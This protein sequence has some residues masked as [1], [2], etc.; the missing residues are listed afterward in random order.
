MADELWIVTTG[1]V[2][3]HVDAEGKTK[4][5][6]EYPASEL[7]RLNVS[8][9]DAPLTEKQAKAIRKLVGKLRDDGLLSPMPKQ[10]VQYP[11]SKV[12]NVKQSLMYLRCW[13][14]DCDEELGTTADLGVSEG[15]PWVEPTAV[16]PPVQESQAATAASLATARD[17]RKAAEPAAGV[18]QEPQLGDLV[19][20]EE[21]DGGDDVPGQV[22]LGEGMSGPE[23]EAWQSVCNE[24]LS[25]DA[26][27]EEE[28]L[29]V[30]GD[31]GP[32]TR[33]VTE[34]VQS[35]LGV[36]VTGLVDGDT[37]SAIL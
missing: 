2:G 13:T 24:V 12:P 1:D 6:K 29:L 19:G 9:D 25:Q 31:F 14:D 35:I 7:A 16:A 28:L 21:Y 37:W 20:G 34:A 30:D 10:G 23:V 27:S 17:E 5:N 26:N 3:W 15:V 11:N 36:P 8:V 18:T 22:T 33:I 32:G 4:A